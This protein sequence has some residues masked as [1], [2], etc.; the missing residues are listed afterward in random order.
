MHLSHPI[1]EGIVSLSV[2]I[3]KKKALRGLSGLGPLLVCSACHCSNPGL[4]TVCVYLVISL[5]LSRTF[6]GCSYTT[7]TN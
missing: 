1:Q 6:A 7:S 3:L 2:F 4:P 5:L